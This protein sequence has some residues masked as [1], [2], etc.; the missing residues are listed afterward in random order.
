MVNQLRAIE[1]AL[2][3]IVLGRSTFLD[4]EPPDGLASSWARVRCSSGASAVGR[5]AR[6]GERGWSQLRPGVHGQDRHEAP[7]C[8]KHV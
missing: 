5:P 2:A 8:R 4:L 3:P 6:G 7:D 1:V